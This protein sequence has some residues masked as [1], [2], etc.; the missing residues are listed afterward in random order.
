M[1]K[2]LKSFNTELSWLIPVVKNRKKIY[3]INIVENKIQND[4]VPDETKKF[5][6]NFNRIMESYRTNVVP[7]NSQKFSYLQQQIN[8]IQLLSQGPNNRE[9]VISKVNINNNIHTIID[10]LDEYNSSVSI[11][12][13]EDTKL[14]SHHVLL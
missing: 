1:I 12:V 10:N 8:N 13:D 11:Y 4:I 7:D 5:I 2:N 9:N 6:N 14:F 3:D